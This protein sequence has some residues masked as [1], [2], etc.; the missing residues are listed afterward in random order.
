MALSSS[1]RPPAPARAAFRPLWSFRPPGPPRGLAPAREKGT[2]FVW[3]DGQWLSLLD[4]RGGR[5]G[6]AHAPWPVAAA[7]AADDG[8]AYAAAGGDG[9]LW[10]LAPDL[11]ARWR[12]TLRRPVVA[13]ALDPFGQYLAAADAGAGLHF[14]DRDGRRAWETTTPRPLHHL[15]FVPEEPLL[16][17]A[18]DFGLVAGFDLKGQAVWRDGLVVHCG[19]LATSGDGARVVLACFSDGLRHYTAAGAR[20]GTA[21]TGEPCRLAALSFD[22]RRTLVAGRAPRL[23]LLDSHG[24]LVASHVL[25]APPVA[26]ALGPLAEHAVAA[27]ADGRVVALDPRAGP[28][29]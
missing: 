17:G 7:A 13:V 19:S 2:V 20:V 1:P 18:A 14:F 21:S 22:G 23:L 25:E 6:Q 5:Q 12:R 10:W 27:L 15:A 9:S 16:I 29:G 3:D 8:S 26:I 24:K 4:R 28:A 11:S